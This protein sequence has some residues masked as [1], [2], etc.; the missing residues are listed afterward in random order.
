[1]DVVV[2]SCAGIDIG[3]AAMCQTEIL[4]ADDRG[5]GGEMSCGT[6]GLDDTEGNML[7]RLEIRL[8]EKAWK[9]CG[10]VVSLGWAAWRGPPA[11]LSCS[12]CPVPEATV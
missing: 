9:V 1:M 11:S 5:G 7:G 4:G 12:S 10:W 8:A 3:K 6:D 2:T